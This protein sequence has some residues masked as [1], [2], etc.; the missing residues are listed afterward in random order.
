M[1]I[2]GIWRIRN[3]AQTMRL[4]G[5]ASSGY[6]QFLRSEI[7]PPEAYAAMRTLYRRTNGRYNDL[8]AALS[9]LFHPPRTSSVAKGVLGDLDK[10]SI[11]G[12]T[13]RIRR[14]GYYIFERKL[15]ANLQHELV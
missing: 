6:R 10:Q 12:I 9:G 2:P 11:L 15:P 8:M 7:T 3:A 13:A 1:R 4:V 14:D 5:R